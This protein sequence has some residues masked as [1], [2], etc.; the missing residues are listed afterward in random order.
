MKPHPTGY[1][2]GASAG[3]SYPR[4]GDLDQ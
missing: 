3:T 1:T 4:S 2:A